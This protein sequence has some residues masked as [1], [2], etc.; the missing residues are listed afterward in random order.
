MPKVARALADF[1]VRSGMRLPGKHSAGETD[2]DLQ[3]SLKGI[4][5]LDGTLFVC[6]AWLTFD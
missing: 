6:V 4:Q 3:P 5:K 2:T 1:A